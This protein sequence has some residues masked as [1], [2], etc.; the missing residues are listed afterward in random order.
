VDKPRKKAEQY[1][2]VNYEEI[3][4]G[5]N[6]PKTKTTYPPIWI[7]GYNKAIDDYESY[8]NS[9]IKQIYKPWGFDLDEQNLYTD[10]DGKSV[11]KKVC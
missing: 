2:E 8:H 5:A 4:E 9:V 3:K 11:T 1:V 7:C 6:Y 10:F